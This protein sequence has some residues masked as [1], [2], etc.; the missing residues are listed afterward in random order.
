MRNQFE[1]LS[2]SLVTI[3]GQNGPVSVKKGHQLF[4]QIVTFKLFT[5]NIRIISFKK[6]HCITNNRILTDTD[7]NYTDTYIGYIGIGISIG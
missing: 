1:S 2:F 6:T 3:I 5:N 7:T 4:C